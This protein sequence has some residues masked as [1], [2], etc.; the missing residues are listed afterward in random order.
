MPQIPGVSP[1]SPAKPA[2]PSFEVVNARSVVG[3]YKYAAAM[4]FMTKEE[5]NAAA[6]ALKKDG[7]VRIP[8]QKTINDRIV[9]RTAEQL[10][11]I[12]LRMTEQIIKQLSS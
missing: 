9:A 10:Q 3:S 11:E 2:P 4:P 5:L 6:S 12:Q 1:T 7:K 8:N